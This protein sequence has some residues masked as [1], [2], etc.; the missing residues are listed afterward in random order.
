MQVDKVSIVTACYNSY[1]TLYRC[2]ESL[3]NQT[4]GIENLECI[5]VDDASTD[6][7]KTLSILYEIEKEAPDNV[8]VIASDNNMGPGGALN[9]G[10]SYATGLYLQILDSDDELSEDAIEKL[11]SIAVEYN[12]DIIQYN[13]TL[14]MGIRA[15]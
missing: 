15:G 13:H 3:K 11:H 12:T 7:G 8:I 10:I 5:F 6:E 9:L 2:W 4:Y 1:E 14:I